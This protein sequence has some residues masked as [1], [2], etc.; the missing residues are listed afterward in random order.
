[1]PCRIQQYQFPHFQKPGP[2]IYNRNVISKYD[3][4]ALMANAS[5]CSKVSN[6]QTE[7]KMHRYLAALMNTPVDTCGSRIDAGSE[8]V[9]TA[10]RKGQTASR[11]K[12]IQR[13]CH[14]T[15]L[16]SIEDYGSSSHLEKV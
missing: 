16:Y 6:N 2:T 15:A 7:K 3:V 14:Q 5:S 10:L 9:H 4:T 13:S 1:M 8:H 12:V 11:S